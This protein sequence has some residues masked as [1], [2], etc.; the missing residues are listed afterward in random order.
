MNNNFIKSINLNE[1]K[2]TFPNISTCEIIKSGGEGIVSKITFNNQN[3]VYALKIYDP[4]HL[5]KRNELEVKKLQ[6]LKSQNIIELYDY[7][8]KSINCHDCFFTI[9][10][11]IEGS[12]LRVMLQNNYKFSDQEIVNMILS[13]SK[14]IDELWAVNVVHCDIKPDNILYNK[15]TQKFILID[16]G[17]AK[18]IDEPTMTA[19]GQIMG[20]KGYIAPEQVQGR[21]NLTLK[22]DFYSLGIVAYELLTGK[23]PYNFN[24]L[25]I[26]QH[27]PLPDFEIYTDNEKLKSIIQILTNPIPYNRP[28]NYIQIENFLKE[29]Y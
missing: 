24:Q 17:I 3:G 20:T 7:G 25:H 12:D 2:A 22:T 26:M 28:F 10:T 6:S 18:Y 11:F 29:E 23:H 8:V 21:K 16:L 13:I 14:A 19:Y 27:K 1:I 5:T 4:D 15:T 9:T